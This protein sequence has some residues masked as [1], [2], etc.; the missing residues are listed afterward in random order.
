MTK[1]QLTLIF[2]IMLVASILVS[3]A[4]VFGGLWYMKQS[5]SNQSAEEWLSDTPLS[6]LTEDNSAEKAPSYHSLE[7]VVLSVKGK[8]QNHFLMLELAVETR[9]PEKIA[10]INDYMPVVENSLIKLFSDKTYEDLQA[11]GAVDHLQREVKQTILTAF[12]KT[13]IIRNI[14]DVLLTKYVVQ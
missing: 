6:F 10:N 8:Q 5:S 1:K 2:I 9:N 4:T 3:A 7:K 11:D 14:D 12:D 13:P